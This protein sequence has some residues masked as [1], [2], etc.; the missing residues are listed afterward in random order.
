MSETRVPMTLRDQFLQDPFFNSSWSDMEK[1]KEHF[2]QQAQ[3][4]NKRFED[5][6]SKHESSET[7]NF[8]TESGIET[9]SSMVPSVDSVMSRNWMLP[10][11]WMMPKL[12]ED[13]FSSFIDMKD[14]N[15]IS[16]KNDDSKMEISLNTAGYK[17]SELKVNVADGEMSIEGKHEEKS[18]EGHTMVSRQFSKRYTL[19]AEAKLTEVVSNLSQDG[20]MVITV[21]KEK[22][23]EEVKENQKMKVEHKT[24]VGRKENGKSS[25]SLVP[26]TMRDS[27]SNDPFFKDTWLDIESSQK[28]FLE[29]S[30]KQ[31]EESIKNMKSAMDGS[32]IFDTEQQSVLPL[33]WS[34]PKIFTQESASIDNSKDS[35]LIRLV[36]D[37]SKMEIS[38]DTTGYKPDELKVS[39]GQGVICVE[40]KHEEKSEAGQVMV[41]RQFSR[42][43]S[44]PAGARA[45]EVV[46]NLSQ[47]GVLGISVPKRE[48]IQQENRS[49]PIAVK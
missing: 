27:F 44:L 13:D 40:G 34:M 9:K 4:M 17:P 42:K 39:A 12:F 29:K 19:P 10:R 45:E 26:L 43:Y 38:L 36:N 23:I 25:E 37:D 15:L 31:F 16:L 46:S 41:A 2:S 30:R 28:N 5:N 21:P 20:V 47:D 24:S 6:W 3:N 35:N 1:F 14:S 48:A 33:D 22:R 8:K 32:S 18:E 11:K 49:V 7:S